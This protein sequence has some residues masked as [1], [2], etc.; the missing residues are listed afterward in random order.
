[1]LDLIMILLFGRAIVLTPDPIDITS[2]YT[3]IEFKNQVSAINEG[4]TLNILLSPNSSITDS[5]KSD[6]DP[7]DSLE[8][9]LPKNTIDAVLK[10]S[11]GYE[12]SLKNNGILVSDFTL[13]K[14]GYA[15]I[16]L[17]MTVGN[18]LDKEF[19]SM[20]IKSK[21]PVKNIKILWQNYSK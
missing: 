4:A 20:K 9:L 19:K 16:P 21:V 18:L 6:K 10:D 1:M 5:I 13:T 2:E 15:R 11:R 14:E 17:S 8:K 12:I 3:Y 7:F